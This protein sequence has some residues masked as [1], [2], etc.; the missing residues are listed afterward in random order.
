MCSTFRASNPSFKSKVYQ[1]EYDTK[2]WRYF[3]KFENQIHASQL[4]TVA[5][6]V[7]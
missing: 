5:K 6:T 2:Y 4:K 3:D 1:T 7:T